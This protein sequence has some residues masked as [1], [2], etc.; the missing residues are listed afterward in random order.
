MKAILLI[1][2]IIS[3]LLTSCERGEI[4]TSL[5]TNDSEFL[6]NWSTSMFGSLWDSSAH[7]SDS[8]NW[9]VYALMSKNLMPKNHYPPFVQKYMNAFSTNDS[10]FFKRLDELRATYGTN[11]PIHYMDTFYHEISEDEFDEKLLSGKFDVYPWLDTNFVYP[12]RSAAYLGFLMQ[13]PRYAPTLQESSS[14][15]YPEFKDINGKI[16]DRENLKNKIV[17][18][19]YW[20]LAC[21]PCREEIPE[22]NK[23]V[24]RYKDNPSVVFLGIAPDTKE[25]IQTA[26]N[27]FDF[28][29]NIIPNSPILLDSLHL[30][31][32]PSHEVIDKNG[33][34]VFSCTE[35][36]ERTISWIMRMIE[37]C[38]AKN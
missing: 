21:V 6:F 7:G 26:L 9:K 15:N 5:T 22:L 29:Y 31:G 10:P 3:I 33:K 2:G 38:L 25:K 23:L 35:S 17:V 30:E 4:H 8:N 24:D 16:Y 20:F 37:F 14:Y 27:T 32:F 28:K 19:N 18:I 36:G 11:M 12:K 34:I 1:G 13:H